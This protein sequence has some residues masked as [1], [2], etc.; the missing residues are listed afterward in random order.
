MKPFTIIFIGPQGSGKGTQIAKLDEVLDK[1]DPTRQVVDIQTG[2]RFRALAAKGEGY[3]EEHI[4]ETLDSGILQP[5]F[6]SVVL[7]GD[8]MRERVDQDCHLLIDGFPRI[9][10]EARVLET[11]LTFY[12][13]DPLTIVNLDTPEDVVRKR[14]EGRARSDDTSESIEERLKWYRTETLPVVEYYRERENTNVI[15]VD[16]TDSID[17]VHAQ[18][19]KGLGINDD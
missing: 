4:Q 16:G 10:R 15:D 9:V 7:W 3:T 2:R 6:L 11:A 12:K 17:G 14:M 1:K 18:I 8:A 13:R 5:L 19:L